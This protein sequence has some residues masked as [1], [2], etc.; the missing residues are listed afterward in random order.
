MSNAIIEAMEL[1]KVA[2]ETVG[3]I[4][5]DR[6][7]EMEHKYEGEKSMVILMGSRI[8]AL[9]AELEAMRSSEQNISEEAASLR[10]RIAESV[11]RAEAAESQAAKYRAA[12]ERIAKE[13]F[14]NP[15]SCRETY[16]RNIARTALEG[17]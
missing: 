8:E 14:P 17:E 13:K 15:T 10:V 16:L 2:A 3:D 6:Y 12:L 4:W 5:R 9:T 1:A 11:Q 7:K